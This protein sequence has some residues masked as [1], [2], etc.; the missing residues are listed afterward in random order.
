[1]AKNRDLEFAEGANGFTYLVDRK[2]DSV[3]ASV[4]EV[5]K[6][7]FEWTFRHK[8]ESIIGISE[9][10]DSAKQEILDRVKFWKY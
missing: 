7:E 3:V 9:S 10:M 1:M 5:R 2:E 4:S 6:D 8:M